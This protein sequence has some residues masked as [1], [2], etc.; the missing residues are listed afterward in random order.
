MAYF[1]RK[2]RYGA[3]DGDSGAQF[4]ALVEI[5][6][7]KGGKAVEF[8]LYQ[9]II[10]YF[11][12]A[13]NITRMIRLSATTAEE[14]VSR[15]WPWDEGTGKEFPGW[16]SSQWEKTTRW[17]YSV[18]V[19]GG[20]EQFPLGA[21]V[22]TTTPNPWTNRRRKSHGRACNTACQLRYL[23]CEMKYVEAQCLV[24]QSDISSA[25]YNLENFD[26]DEG[27]ERR[28]L[29]EATSRAEIFG[30]RLEEL[31]NQVHLLI[32]ELRYTKAKKFGAPYWPRQ[33]DGTLKKAV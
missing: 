18:A 3:H 12:P 11:H 28:L 4:M 25:E 30:A 9:K 20:Y 17:L 24:A 1:A 5:T 8:V 13:E 6:K 19:G 15:F 16:K 14:A 2:L 26:D 23:E 22:K 10:Q 27:E 7:K 32:D 21:W 33:E 31:N 29:M